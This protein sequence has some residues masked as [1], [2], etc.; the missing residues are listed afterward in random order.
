MAPRLSGVD[1]T[2]L[3]GPQCPRSSSSALFSSF[4]VVS[5]SSRPALLHA[6]LAKESK[7]SRSPPPP[8]PLPLI[9]VA[10]R[11]SSFPGGSWPVALRG[12][13]DL[14]FC[15]SLIKA[16]GL[17]I[18]SGWAGGNTRGIKNW[19]LPRGEQ[20]NRGQSG[21]GPCEGDWQGHKSNTG[22]VDRSGTGSNEGSWRA[23]GTH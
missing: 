19:Q 4:V 21:P 2:A 17:R 10:T 8:P 1:V 22:A 9:V 3:H 7:E 20:Q 11:S 14:C 6:V 12:C 15:T 16:S 23:R 18:S 5:P 13:C